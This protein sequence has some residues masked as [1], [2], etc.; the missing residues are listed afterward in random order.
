M[1][2]RRI[3]QLA[4]VVHFLPHRSAVVDSVRIK[5]DPH[6]ATACFEGKEGLTTTLDDGSRARAAG[7]T[8]RVA[9]SRIVRQTHTQV[10]PR[11]CRWAFRDGKNKT[12]K[13]DSSR[14]IIGGLRVRNVALWCVLGG[15][16]ALLPV[17]LLVPM[18]QQIFHFAPIRVDD[19]VL[20]I[21]V[22]LARRP[23]FD[24]FKLS[25]HWAKTNVAPNVT[26]PVREVGAA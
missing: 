12:D 16:A 3:R 14:T 18:A 2:A 21:G 22:N 17:V 24:L 26:R 1:A 10:K 6:Y 20:S 15:A 5:L 4:N 13:P 9:D 11:R 7:A 19:L 25:K 23:W 8:S